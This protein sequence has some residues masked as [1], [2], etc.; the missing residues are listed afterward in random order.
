MS[1]KPVYLRDVAQIK[2][3]AEEPSQYVF[4]GDGAATAATANGQPAVTLTIAKRPGANAISVANEV[5]KKMDTLKGRII[6]N[7]VQVT[8]TRN[9][10]ATAEEKSNELLLH[11]G[12]AVIGVSL[13]ILLALG[14]RESGIVAIAD[15]RP[16]SR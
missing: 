7:D 13:L 10:G 9:Y 16:R 4:F 8:V 3:G 11:M 5:L 15:S 6:P 14:W 1:G 2:D 12:I